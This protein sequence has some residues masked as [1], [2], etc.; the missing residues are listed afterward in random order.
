MMT[1]LE[2]LSQ[3]PDTKHFAM[4]D[5]FGTLSLSTAV[6]GGEASRGLLIGECASINSEYI[7]TSMISHF[8]PIVKPFLYNF[9]KK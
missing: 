7:A 5:I 3:G 9:R 2:M 6:N 4:L 8:V 1:V